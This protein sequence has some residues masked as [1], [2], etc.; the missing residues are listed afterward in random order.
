MKEDVPAALKTE[1][2]LA[3]KSALVELESNSQLLLD[4]EKSGQI[5]IEANDKGS[6][7]SIKSFGCDGA[8]LAFKRGAPNMLGQVAQDLVT[9]IEQRLRL[10]SWYSKKYG[11]TLIPGSAASSG[12]KH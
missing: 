5:K 12:K 9:A 4:A 8:K 11:V 7:E 6:I 1:F 3:L 10:L 2:E